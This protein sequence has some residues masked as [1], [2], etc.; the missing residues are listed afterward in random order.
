M[1]LVTPRIPRFRIEYVLALLTAAAA[2]YFLLPPSS[3]QLYPPFQSFRVL[4]RNGQV[5]REVL[6][7]DY[8]TSIWVPLDQISPHIIEA[9]VLEED[10]RFFYHHGVDPIALGRALFQNIKR[11]RTISGGSTITMQVA[12]MILNLRTRNIL[13]KLLE[14]AY[15]FKL[16]LHLSKKR[17]LEIYLNRTPYGNQTYG[18]GAASSLYFRKPVRDLSAG[19]ACI[20]A[21][22]PR[23]PAC[24]NPYNSPRQVHHRREALLGKLL[25]ERRIDSLTFACARAESL[26][27]QSRDYVFKAP[28]FVDYVL[29]A[30]EQEAVS[31][32]ADITTTLDFELEQDFEKLL[33]TT[34]ASL[35]KYGVG[36]GA[37]LVA[38]TE[39]GE[40]LAMVGS[41]NYYDER[42]GQ[43]NGCLAL[44]QPGSTIKPF[45]YALALES[46]IPTSYVIPDTILEFRLPDGSYFAPRNYGDRYH[47]PTRAR[48]ALG[49]SF[50]VP[51]VY[52]LEKIG[53][54]RFHQ[55]LREL[56]FTSLAKETHFYGLSL[57]LGAGEVTLLDLVNAY[58]AIARHG[59]KSHV[60]VLRSTTTRS[61]PAFSTAAAAIITDILADNASRFKAFGDDSPLNLPFPCAAKTGTSKDFRDNWCIGFTRKYSVGVWVG[62]FDGS[63][64]QG[65]SGISGAAPL[66]RD[67]MIELHREA[68]PSRF[69][70]PS[71]LS[72]QRI[73]ARSGKI[74]GRACP[75]FVEELFI[76]GTPPDDSCPA[77][78]NPDRSAHHFPTDDPRLLKRLAI[79]KP[80]DGDLYSLDPQ[81]STATQAILL[82]ARAASPQSEV[83][84]RLDGRLLGTKHSPFEILW[85]PVPGEHKLV[86]F[87]R[88]HANRADSVSFRVY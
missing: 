36:Q 39:T 32:T 48:E 79:L 38:D 21:V 26:N 68:Y 10:R 43:V 31:T 42:E 5:L 27:I 72:R 84:F 76:P 22:I 44:R 77:C 80:Q 3:A 74:P 53:I 83:V 73:C 45:L 20:L 67:I 6:S 25:E 52:L 7:R 71:A 35:A 18:V 37:I 19:E 8:K 1:I 86:V 62:N 29:A 40:I 61:V 47:G 46:G 81:V 13:S 87:D 34:L 14:M 12:K 11:G 88:E 4:D 85:P 2:G 17:I 78:A 50:N 51:A 57:S 33:A 82:R 30:A 60:K 55:F 24:L 65:V 54:Q 16:E 69:E 75:N 49:S 59:L 56:G 28:H 63:P 58:R 66:F 9:T 41:K 70:E 15:A 64:M 23:S